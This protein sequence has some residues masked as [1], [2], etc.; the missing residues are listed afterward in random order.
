[1]HITS[2]QPFRAAQSRGNYRA[3]QSWVVRECCL[4]IIALGVIALAAIDLSDWQFSWMQKLPKKTWII[5]LTAGALL[6]LRTMIFRPFMGCILRSALYQLKGYDMVGYNPK[7]RE[8]CL[9]LLAIVLLILSSVAISPSKMQ[10]MDFL[11]SGA[12]K[13]GVAAGSILTLCTLF[14]QAVTKLLSGFNQDLL[15][16]KKKHSAAWSH[17]PSTTIQT[18]NGAPIKVSM[19]CTNPENP[20]I[21]YLPGSLALYDHEEPTMWEEAVKGE[22]NLLFYHPPQYGESPGERTPESDY[23]AAEALLQYLITPQEQGGMGSSEDKIHLLGYSIGTGAAIEMMSKYRLGKSILYTPFASVDSLA[24]RLLR[25]SNLSWLY[26][27]VASVI[28][29][30]GE[31]NSRDKMA[32]LETRELLIIQK[33]RDEL[34]GTQEKGGQ[35][36]EGRML[37]EAWAQGIEA[38]TH[39]N[40]AGESAQIYMGEGRSLAFYTYPGEHGVPFNICSLKDLLRKLQTP[41]K[42]ELASLE[43]ARAWALEQCALGRTDLVC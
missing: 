31:Y 15:E 35:P 8:I 43:R 16:W 13:I 2:T 34:M 29:D 38:D 9:C 7:K 5:L 1:M 28:R 32:Q 10:W 41:N 30:Y 6:G 12:W 39:R 21:V 36:G 40:G 14:R 23:L 17:I 42:E 18:L 27:S 3:N 25:S 4:A 22:Y 26:S 24:R 37:V 19:I 11:P 33:K 20:W